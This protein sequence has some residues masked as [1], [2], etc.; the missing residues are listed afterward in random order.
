[1]QVPDV[2]SLGPA[3]EKILESYSSYSA[4]ARRSAEERFGI[5]EMVDRYVAVL[6]AGL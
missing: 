5:D 6:E 4:A 3:A 2:A 1:M